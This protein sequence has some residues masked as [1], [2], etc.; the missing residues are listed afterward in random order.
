MSSTKN[1]GDPAKNDFIS[2]VDGLGNLNDKP[3]QDWDF[4]IS[5]GKL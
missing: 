2:I 5:F 3:K 1:E 4:G